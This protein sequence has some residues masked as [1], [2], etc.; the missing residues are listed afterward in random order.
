MF[1]YHILYLLVK[2]VHEGIQRALYSILKN[3]LRYRK[4]PICYYCTLHVLGN[5]IDKGIQRGNKVHERIQTALDSIHK[6]PICYRKSP[7]FYNCTLYL[8]GNK[9][10]EGV[11]PL[12]L[13]Q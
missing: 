12:D 6:T 10:D 11:R 2:K 5:E 7:I 9:V 4:S 13:Q 3:P 1:Y 8:L